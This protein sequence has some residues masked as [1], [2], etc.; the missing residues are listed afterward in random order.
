MSLCIYAV[1]FVTYT[2]VIVVYT[3]ISTI[4]L[5]STIVEY[6]PHSTTNSAMTAM[7]QMAERADRCDGPRWALQHLDPNTPPIR[8]PTRVKP[9]SEPNV[10]STLPLPSGNDSAIRAVQAIFRGGPSDA[11]RVT[12]I[13]VDDCAKRVH[14]SVWKRLHCNIST[15]R[16]PARNSTVHIQHVDDAHLLVFVGCREG[17]LMDVLRDFSFDDVPNVRACLV[18]DFPKMRALM[19]RKGLCEADRPTQWSIWLNDFELK[20]LL[21][22]WRELKHPP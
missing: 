11:C 6:K 7:R 14:D 8:P 18:T 10:H 16:L 20:R 1:L 15:I 13:V 12:E 9:P 17:R 4:Q 19:V 22:A 21:C 2:Y 5:C 3:R